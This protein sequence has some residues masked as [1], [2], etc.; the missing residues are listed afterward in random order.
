MNRHTKH[1]ARACM[2]TADST[3]EYVTSIQVRGCRSEEDAEAADAYGDDLEDY[4][5]PH[6]RGCLVQ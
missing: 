2:H 6:R 4:D 5:G 1:D 3:H